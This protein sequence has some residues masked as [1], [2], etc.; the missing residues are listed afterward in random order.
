MRRVRRCRAGGAGPRALRAVRGDRPVTAGNRPLVVVGGAPLD[1]DLVGTASRLTPDAPVP[2]VE[3]VETRDRPGGAAL[4]AVIAAA[5]TGRE[6]VLV[7]PMDSDDGAARLGAPRE[8][9]VRLV[10]IPATGGTAVKQRVRVGNH[11][12]VRMDSGA[13]VAT[14]GAVPAAAT[15]AIRDAPPAAARRAGAAVLAADSGGGTTAAPG[16]REALSATRAPIV[17][18]PHPRGAD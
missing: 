18:D 15:A 16:I 1:V 9:R 2:V 8:G 4:A 7:A 14:L 12:V 3:D 6:V 5:A 10:P 13:P 11:S 17:W